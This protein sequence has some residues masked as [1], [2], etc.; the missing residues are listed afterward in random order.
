MTAIHARLKGV[1]LFE[2]IYLSTARYDDSIFGDLILTKMG[3]KSSKNTKWGFV[4]DTID[5]S[6]SS[7][8]KMFTFCIENY[9]K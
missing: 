3:F 5:P 9:F 1:E 7:R 8:H 4:M 6:I 2:R